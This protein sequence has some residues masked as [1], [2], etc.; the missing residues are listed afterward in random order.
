MFASNS[1]LAAIYNHLASGSCF[2]LVMMSS[3]E[4]PYRFISVSIAFGSIFRLSC[5][6]DF[7]HVF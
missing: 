6:V 4:I 7:I 3:Y 1:N 5:I 2:I